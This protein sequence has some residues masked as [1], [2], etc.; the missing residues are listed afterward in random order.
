MGSVLLRLRE[1]SK[2]FTPTEKEVARHILEDPRLVEEL[3]VHEL[4]KRTYASPSTIVRMCN[5][6]GYA[7]YKEF[8]RAVIQELIL[9]D[10]N[11]KEERKQLQRSDTLEDI[12]TKVTYRNI[13][14]LEDTK[15]LL[16]YDVLRRCLHM[17]RNARCI[18]LF[19][20][21]ASLCAA[22]DAY[23]KFLRMNKP[24][25]VNEDW[26]SQLLQ[27]RNATGEDLGIAF[28]YS[29]HTVEV[30]ECMKALKQN[31]VPSIA[32]TRCVSS[33]VS[34]LADERLYTTAS[35]ALFRS[36][37]MSSRISQLN[38]IDILYAA[39]TNEEYDLA[40]DQ[41]SRTHI[42]KPDESEGMM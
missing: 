18:Y 32:I 31:H 5:H 36:G 41:F 27:A 4:A 38:I 10:Q 25:V 26:H 24:C 34:D 13:M 16:D 12:V 11:K 2:G 21:G 40:L 19:G 42:H 28:S 22:K 39:L 23:L 3:S 7:G 15:D 8:R 14:S 20:M 9:R 6:T 17:I 1:A 29:G 37:A 35:E 30:V 33:P